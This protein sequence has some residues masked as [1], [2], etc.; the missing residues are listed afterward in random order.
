WWGVVVL[1]GWCLLIWWLWVGGVFAGCV[2]RS[3]PACVCAGGVWCG[4]FVWLWGWFV[5]FC[6]VCFWVFFLCLVVGCV[7][8]F[9]CVWVL[10]RLLV[11]LVGLGGLFLCLL[12]VGCFWF[13]GFVVV[14]FVVGG[15]GCGWVLVDWIVGVV[16][17]LLLVGC[18]WVGGG[19][20]VLWWLWWGC[21]WWGVRG[22]FCFVVGWCC[23]FFWLG[24]FVLGLCWCFGWFVV[25][26]VWCVF[27]FLLG[28][29]CCGWV[30]WVLCGFC[31]WGWWCFWGVF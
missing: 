1:V 14:V 31:C 7:C 30:G 11:M 17:V 6:G 26:L 16:V 5:L 29:L 8:W 25:W 21:V 22:C 12:G 4:G 3:F 19:F 10:L 28:L 23:W 27:G 20:G 18:V 13:V 9:C 2:G 24:L 15:V